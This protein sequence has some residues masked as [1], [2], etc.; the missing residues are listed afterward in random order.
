MISGFST[1]PRHVYGSNNFRYYGGLPVPFNIPNVLHNLLFE[2]V[3]LEFDAKQSDMI[4]AVSFSY[5]A[6]LRMQQIYAPKEQEAVVNMLK[7]PDNLKLK[8]EHDKIQF[9]VLLANQ[10]FKDLVVVLSELLT[11]D[12]YAKLLE[13]SNIKL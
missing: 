11:R 10:H 12:Q 13:F 8:E 9:D 7:N 5:K 2:D 1:T 3:G 6:L 4:D